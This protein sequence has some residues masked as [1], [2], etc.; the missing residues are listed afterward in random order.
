MA[1][2]ELNHLTKKFGDFTAVDDLSLTVADSEMVALLGESG[3]GKT[4]TLRMIAGFTEINSGTV[5]IDGT[6][7]NSIPAYKRNVG[8]F[9]QNYALFPHLRPVIT[10]PLALN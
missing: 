8:I 9:F 1:I 5:T 10:S 4:T 2:L 7:M 3:C 6:A